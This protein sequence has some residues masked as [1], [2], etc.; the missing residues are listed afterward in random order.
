MRIHKI[1]TKLPGDLEHAVKLRFLKESTL[2][3][4]SNKLQELRIRISIGRYNTNS[5]GNNRHNPT[6]EA[7]KAHDSEAE[8]TNVSHNYGS[9]NHYA[10][11]NSKD[12]E[13]I[14][15]PEEE[16]IKYQGSESDSNSVGNGCRD[17]SYS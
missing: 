10:D 9:P 6:L 12:R 4:I 7:N 17:D 11:N 3:Q 13:E 2:D 1:L 8:I 15:P 16:T 14:F 5:T